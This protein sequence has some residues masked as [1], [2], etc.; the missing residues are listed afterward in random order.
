MTTG[1]CHG[2][3]TEARF[4][5]PR[6]C[7]ARTLAAVAI[8]EWPFLM[9]ACSRRP[10]RVAV[11]QAA[12]LGNGDDLASVIMRRECTSGARDGQN[13]KSSV[14]NGDG[15]FGRDGPAGHPTN[16]VKSRIASRGRNPTRQLGA[17]Q[18]LTVGAARGH[19]EKTRRICALSR[20]VPVNHVRNRA[21]DLG[22]TGR[23]LNR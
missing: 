7:R 16:A 1:G 19:F 13:H 15:V 11:M 4:R 18:L 10:T 8:S 5:T 22:G 2:R 12:D 14:D 9:A 17:L 3:H 6:T 23:S 21:L 20:P